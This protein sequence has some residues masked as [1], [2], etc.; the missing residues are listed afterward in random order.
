MILVK[1]V[2]LRPPP[3]IPFYGIGGLKRAFA[4]KH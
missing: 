3:D 4:K 1:P 2:V